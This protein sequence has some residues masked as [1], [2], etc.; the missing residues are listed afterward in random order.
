MIL[1]ECFTDEFIE[2]KAGTNVEK[3]KIY[4][5]VV[6]AFCLLEKL[7]NLKLD[8][9]FKGGT[10]L[11]LLLEEFNRFS[12]DID[13]L[14]AKCHIQNID[15]VILKLKDDIFIEVEED[16]R[17]PSEIIKKHYKFYFKSIYA[18][19]E[20]LSYVLL[21]IVF[22]DLKYKDVSSFEIAS[23]YIKVTYPL[24]KVKI[25][26]I[27]EMIGDKLTAFAPKT[28]GILY[29]QKSP[30][31]SKNIEI[32]KQLYDVSKLLN[33]MTNLEN[34]KNTYDKVAEVQR[35][36]RLLEISNEECLYDSINAC[37][38]IISQGKFG[39]TIEEYNQLMKG[40]E[41]FKDFVINRFEY[42][43]FLKCATLVYILCIKLLYNIE[44]TEEEKPINSFVGRRYKLILMSIGE[45]LYGELMKAIFV[46]NSIVLEKKAS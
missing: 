14:M 26:S 28:I 15:E 13:I 35:K 6:Y 27:D 37:K 25:P 36:N 1:K 22:D 12:V 19:D 18:K 17:K 8:F 34:V 38:L 39:G 23:H 21:D 33:K 44:F 43:E 32:V 10:S 30:F 20:K 2:S 46:E 24:L 9:V 45:E 40:Y 16:L 31:V 42:A 11:M 29:K 41:G 3:K 7:S 4:E 5:K